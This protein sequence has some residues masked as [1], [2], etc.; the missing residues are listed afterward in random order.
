[1][2]RFLENQYEKEC[3][4]YFLSSTSPCK[5]SARTSF[6]LKISRYPYRGCSFAT[7]QPQA[8][9]LWLLVMQVTTIQTVQQIHSLPSW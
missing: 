7:E 3:E 2:Q 4:C 1:M 8:Q 5:L 9:I 6:D